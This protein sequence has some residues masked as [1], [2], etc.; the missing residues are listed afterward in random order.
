MN[1]AHT[2]SQDYSNVND[3]MTALD[4]AGIESEQD[5]NNGITTWVFD[6]ESKIVVQAD[7]VVIS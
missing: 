2:F 5:W 6:D 7:D 3:L 4:N 1:Q